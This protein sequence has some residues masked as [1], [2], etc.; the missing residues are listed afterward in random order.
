MTTFEKVC[1]TDFI[2]F[3]CRGISSPE[4]QE[5]LFGLAVVFALFFILA[6]KD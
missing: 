4:N 5:L 1:L 6:G 3:M 2:Y